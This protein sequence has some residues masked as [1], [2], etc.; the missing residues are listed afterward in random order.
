MSAFS[1]GLLL[2]QRGGVDPEVATKVMSESAIGSPMLRGRAPLVLHLPDQAWF[3]VELMHKDIRL[4]RQVGREEGVPLPSAAATEAVL[5][6]AEQQ[7]YG[8]QDIAGLFEVLA[9]T[10]A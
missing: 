9:R 10:T 6:E 5:R 4:A 3:D 8:H 7:G 2:A 1:E